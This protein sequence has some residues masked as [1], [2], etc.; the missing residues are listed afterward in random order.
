MNLALLARLHP[1]FT[2]DLAFR[3]C[4]SSWDENRVVTAMTDKPRSVRSIRATEVINDRG[5]A[6]PAS[7]AEMLRLL[8]A[9]AEQGRVVR[10]KAPGGTRSWL[11]SRLPS[12]GSAA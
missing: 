1:V 11:F 10:G 8:H 9:L 6:M 2:D 3:S 4:P 7:H 5:D 12:T